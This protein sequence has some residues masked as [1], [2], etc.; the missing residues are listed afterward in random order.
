MIR[1]KNGIARTSCAQEKE[2]ETREF[3]LARW[4]R[5]EITLL[6]T[7]VWVGAAVLLFQVLCKTAAID[8]VFKV[9]VIPHRSKRKD[10]VNWRGEMRSH[11]ELTAGVKGNSPYCIQNQCTD[12]KTRQIWEHIS[13]SF[14][15][16]DPQLQ[17]LLHGCVHVHVS[18]LISTSVPPDESQDNGCCFLTSAPSAA[19]KGRKWKIKDKKIK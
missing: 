3:G 14:V 8:N 7:H 10:K 4:K 12:S 18:A 17:S 5:G 6:D 15:R 16:I 13:Q 19:I 11:P 1:L 2:K 9:Q